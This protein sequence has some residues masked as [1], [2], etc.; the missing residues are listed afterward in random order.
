M[1]NNIIKGLAKIVVGIILGGA[2]VKT[3]KNGGNDIKNS[4]PKKS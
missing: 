4:K 2:A 3:A 1:G